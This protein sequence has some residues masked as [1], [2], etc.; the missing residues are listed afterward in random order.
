MPPTLKR[1]TRGS[2]SLPVN[3]NAINKE[4]KKQ[5]RRNLHKLRVKEN[6]STMHALQHKEQMRDV[7]KRIQNTIKEENEEN[8]NNFSGGKRTMRNCKKKT[9]KTRKTKKSK[10]YFFGLF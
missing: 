6:G 5:F 2:R 7:P 4:A 1:N 8:N 3:L 9:K 10:K